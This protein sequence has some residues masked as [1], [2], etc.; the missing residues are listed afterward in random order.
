MAT[1]C[2]P[3]VDFVTL[4]CENSLCS[5]EI[6]EH[7]VNI[8]DKMNS[9]EAKSLASLADELLHTNEALIPSS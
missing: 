2:V 9:L 1:I 7:L 3:A 5:R 4:F 8:N 6:C